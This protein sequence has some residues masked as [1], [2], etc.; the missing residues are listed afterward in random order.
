MESDELTRLKERIDRDRLPSHVAIIMDGN[1]R[2]A[3]ERGLDR[4]DGH[5]EGVTT[6]RKITEIAS[7]ERIAAAGRAWAARF[8]DPTRERLVALLTMQRYFLATGQDP[9]AAREPT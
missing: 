4:S 5:A 8:R 7:D 9:D 1:G 2:W 3:R 6:V